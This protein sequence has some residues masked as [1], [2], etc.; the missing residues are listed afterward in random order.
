MLQTNLVQSMSTHIGWCAASKQPQRQPVEAVSVWQSG[1][2]G[3]RWNQEDQDRSYRPNDDGF[4]SG[5]AGPPARHIRMLRSVNSY[6]E[7]R[8][9]N[10]PSVQPIPPHVWRLEQ[11]WELP[12][13]AQADGGGLAGGRR[14]FRG[15]LRGCAGP[16][17]QWSHDRRDADQRHPRHPDRVLGSGQPHAHRLPGR[18]G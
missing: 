12:A 18:L 1:E 4:N 6:E 14:R 7:V 5:H 15:R 13:G 2:C 17:S 10:R 9:S 11:A 8:D 16:G 3:L